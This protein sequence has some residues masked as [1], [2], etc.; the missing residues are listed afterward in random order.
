MAMAAMILGILAIPSFGCFIIGGVLAIVLGAI[1]Y[2]RTN[3]EPETY[4]G[5]GMAIAGIIL[6]AVSFVMIPI[7]GII[8]AI[9]IPSLLRARVAANESAAIGD[10]RTVISGEAAYASQN[11][12][13]YDTLECLGT[14]APCLPG[15]TGPVF[16]DS[17]LAHPSVIPKSGYTRKLHLGPPPDPDG[18]P[19]K[20][21]SSV[22][23][24]AYVA[25]PATQ[26]QTGV[27]AF[28]GDDRGII[29]YWTDGVP[30]EIVDGQCPADCTVIR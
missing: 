20:S 3:K 27:R 24:Y 2:S 13:Y 26:G 6:G 21:P 9:A 11:N 15:Y 17:S 18:P 19:A 25:V 16:L 29:C 7:I 30:T 10:L 23:S 28:C 8:S 5:R 14:P 1:A 4:G 22:R 12:G